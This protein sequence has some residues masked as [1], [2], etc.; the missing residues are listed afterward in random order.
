MSQIPV[1]MQTRA[2]THSILIFSPYKSIHARK[3]KNKPRPIIMSKKLKYVL[4]NLL[5]WWSGFMYFISAAAKM[6]M[7]EIKY[8]VTIK[9]KKLN[10]TVK[11]CISLNTAPTARHPQLIKLAVFAILSL[12]FAFTVSTIFEFYLFKWPKADW[13]FSAA[14]GALSAILIIC[15]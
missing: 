7:N 12:H 5:Y 2:R 1:P 14:A 11:Q 13:G 15:D 6:T 10:L 8:K 9:K 4:I 3:I